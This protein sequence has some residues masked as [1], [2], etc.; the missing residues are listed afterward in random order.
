[1]HEDIQRLYSIYLNHPVIS[2]DT[3][4]ITPGC[5]FFALTGENFNGN[6]F[7]EQAILQG[8][9]YAVVS[10]P[11]LIGA[12]FIH[13]DDTLLTLQQLANH[14]RRQF[15]VPVLA[16]TGSNGKT[17]TKELVS[18]V[19][20]KKFKVHSTK[21]NL[22][23]HI[24]VPLTLLGITPGVEFVVCEMGANHI[25]EIASLCS[26]AEPTAG[27]I[28]NIGKAHLEGFGSLEGVQKG[29]GELYDFLLHHDGFAFVNTDDP[30]LLEI[31]QKLSRKLTYG[32]SSSGN[33][34]IHF[35]YASIPDEPGF[36]LKDGDSTFTL[37][38]YM[39]GHY[40]AMNVLAAYTVGV[41]FEVAFPQIQNAI[42][43]YK[44]GT[45][46]SEI[47]S[48]HGSII[49]KDAYNANPSSMEL[50]LNAFG[51]QYPTGW[52]VLGDM[53]EVGKD[54]QQV[55][56][57]ILEQLTHST[58]ERIFLVGKAFSTALHTLD[59]NDGRFLAM[60]D[61]DALK[62]TW[63]WDQCTGKALL[64]KGS[65]SMHLETLLEPDREQ[66]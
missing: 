1:M 37:R 33:P 4:T 54:E 21:G 53:K 23:N 18:A 62:K 9:A 16:I 45:N 60:D 47:L 28:T 59:E 46:R 63:D 11:A 8:A 48:L 14:H 35:S 7:A 17:T 42:L 30:K 44:A 65:R 32:F 41:H 66:S 10:D 2:T 20:S 56:R 31:S 26:I 5:I 57:M 61:I 19:L 39:F 6:T 40:N 27:L 43:G 38:S 50:A 49:I 64:L 36:I 15:N 24:G 25:G 58:F 51:V 52:V 12:H 55:H 29:K 13:V 34:M 22:N 3:R